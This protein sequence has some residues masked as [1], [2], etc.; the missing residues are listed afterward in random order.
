MRSGNSRESTA[1]NALE[2]RNRAVE[3]KYKQILA[4]NLRAPSPWQ[5]IIHDRHM[6]EKQ[7]HD[8]SQAA[9]AT[10]VNLALPT[11]TPR[12]PTQ[13]VPRTVLPFRCHVSFPSSAQHP[14]TAAHHSV[15]D[16]PFI[17]SIFLRQ[18]TRPTPRFAV[19]E[20]VTSRHD[21][22]FF[23]AKFSN[24]GVR[25][26]AVCSDISY[27]RALELAACAIAREP[28]ELAQQN[29]LYGGERRP[30]AGGYIIE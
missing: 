19:L 20:P 7:Q 6:P 1:A 13:G 25:V 4:H 27:G 21:G 26:G 28:L 11:P 9:T 17:A 8:H 12:P 3:S 2:D 5:L 30:L 24:A 29:R 23:F 16:V 14:I 10:P 18:A 22:K 15:Y